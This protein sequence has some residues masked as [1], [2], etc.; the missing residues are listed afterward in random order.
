MWINMNSSELI[1]INMLS[2]ELI[3]IKNKFEWIYVFACDFIM[4]S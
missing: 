3:W 4:D 2:Y 1:W